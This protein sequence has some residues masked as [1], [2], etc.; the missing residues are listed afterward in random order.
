MT[1]ICMNLL[2]SDHISEMTD[3]KLIRDLFKNQHDYVQDP[4]GIAH[5]E[6]LL[7]LGQ[8]NKM[9]LLRRIYHYRLQEK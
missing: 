3:M 6:I 9:A 4:H 2:S 7:V 5:S 1:D 8:N